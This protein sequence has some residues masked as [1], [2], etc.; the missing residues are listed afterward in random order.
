VEFGAT[1]GRPRRCGWMD[2]VQLRYAK[3]VNGLDGIVMTKL[4]VLC[5]MEKIKI[6]TAYKYKGEIIKKFTNS[7]KI[8]SE[9][10][11][12]YEELDGFD[13]DISEIKEFDKLPKNAKLYIKRVEELLEVE[14]VMVSVGSKRSQTIMVKNPFSLI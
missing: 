4:D 14:T 12:V 8:L 5:G 10:E 7:P 11:P 1:T 13:E 2:A 9:C 3:E 6:C